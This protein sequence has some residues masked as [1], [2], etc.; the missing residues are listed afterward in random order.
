M[1]ATTYGG[2]V[3]RLSIIFIVLLSIGCSNYSNVR[4]VKHVNK[5]NLIV[6]GNNA[7]PK[8]FPLTVGILNSNKRLFCSGTL[9]SH[10]LVMTAAHCVTDML[11]QEFYV[12][13]GCDNEILCD[14]IV[15]VTSM[16]IHHGF[17]KKPGFANWNDIAILLLSKPVFIDTKIKI[18]SPELYGLVLKPGK[19]ITLVGFGRNSRIGGAGNLRYAHSVVTDINDNEITVGENEDDIG[20]ICYGDSGSSFYVVH[21][22]QKYIVGV[23]SRLITA[24]PRNNK[25]CSGGGIYTLDGK[26]SKWIRDEYIGLLTKNISSSKNMS[27]HPMGRCSFSYEKNNKS[28]FLMF[29]LIILIYS[30]KRNICEK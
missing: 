5:K 28:F 14:N 4:H 15:P 25:Y 19:K 9:I 20:N 1:L 18:L 8:L 23:A 10:D 16:S 12:I 24:Y 29:L 22:K 6:G 13:H 7:D 17:E 21:N 30:R 3:K 26:Y 2:I 11:N 27:V